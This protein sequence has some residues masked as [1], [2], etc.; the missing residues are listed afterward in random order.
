MKNDDYENAIETIATGISNTI[1]DRA[2]ATGTELDPGY[3]R[4]V[5]AGCLGIIRDDIYESVHKILTE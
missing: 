3:I 4:G 1:K 5:A 2:T